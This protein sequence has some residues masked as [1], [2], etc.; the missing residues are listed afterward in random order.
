MSKF[1]EI[2]TLRLKLVVPGPDVG[3]PIQNAEKINILWGVGPPIKSEK[4]VGNDL[5]SHPQSS[6]FACPEI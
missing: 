2:K 3:P 4:W 1:T 5:P 6:R